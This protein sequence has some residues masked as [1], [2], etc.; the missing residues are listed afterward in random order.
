[1]KIEKERKRDEGIFQQ[2]NKTMIEFP[3]ICPFVDSFQTPFC[4]MTVSLVNQV[5]FCLKTKGNH[6]YHLYKMQKSYS[7]N[8]NCSNMFDLFESTVKLP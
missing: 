5:I 7:H 6:N 8:F 2:I 4:R 3:K 1:M